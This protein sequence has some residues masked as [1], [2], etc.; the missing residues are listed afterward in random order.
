MQGK[1]QLE[2]IIDTIRKVREGEYVELKKS[3]NLPD[4]FWPTYSAFC[5]TKGGIIFL[6]VSEGESILEANTIR[7]VKNHHK[8]KDDLLNTLSNKNKVSFNSL[9]EDNINV[10]HYEDKT[11]LI[12]QVPEVPIDKKPVFL[13]DK[14]DQSYIRIGSGDVKMTKEQIA[15][16]SRLSSPLGDSQVVANFSVEDLDSA[17]ISIYKGLVANRYPNRTFLEIDNS[18]FLEEIGAVFKNRRTEGYDITVGALLFFGKNNSIKERFP[19]LFLDFIY[20]PDINKRWTSR[21]N[22]DMLLDSEMNVFNF[23]RMIDEKLMSIA[24]NEFKMNALQTRESDITLGNALREA[25]VNSLIHADYYSNEPLVKIEVNDGLYTFNNSGALSINEDQFFLGGKSIAR[26]E[27]LMKLFSLMGKSERQGFG[28][29]LIYEFASINNKKIPQ[30]DSSFDGTELKI[31][32]VDSLVNLPESERLI[33]LFL[34]KK[35]PLASRSQILEGTGIGLNDFKK[36]INKLLDKNMIEKVGKSKATKYKVKMSSQESIN[37]L[38]L[39]LKSLK[40]QF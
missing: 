4:D 38:G 2:N 37:H 18:R 7:G 19:K 5:N 27:I 25:L 14:I 24:P 22:S 13:N 6:G 15:E 11:V 35:M 9:R 12:V 23:F 21:I 30:I 40:S 10:L 28:G 33:Y 34:Y 17:S 3:Q 39:I 26:N 20:R 8:I 31:W 1:M 29:H 36:A 16:Y 32:D